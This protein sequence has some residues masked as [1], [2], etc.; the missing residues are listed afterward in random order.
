MG[1]EKRR[2]RARL[3][4]ALA[5]GTP[6]RIPEDACDAR[7][8]VALILRPG[9]GRDEE[10]PFEL[11]FVQRAEVD[12][13]PWSGHMALPGGRREPP[14][15]DLVATAIRETRE[16]TSLRLTRSDVLGALDDVH[17]FTSHL[18]SIAVTPFV[19]WYEGGGRVRR[20]REVRDHVWVPSLALLAHRNRSAFTLRR[21]ERIASFPTLEFSGYTVWG[22]TF[23]ILSRFLEV[24][25][26]LDRGDR[27]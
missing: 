4:A 17:P 5:A 27:P 2:A 1:D 3:E 26:S 6:R 13:D 23:E 19:A 20:S 21:E 14:D 7:A 8:A 18:P 12:G 24:V 9:R 11:L 15:P 25:R 16:E 10:D 22:L